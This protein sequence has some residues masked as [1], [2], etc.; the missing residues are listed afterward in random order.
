VG[1]RVE[2]GPSGLAFPKIQLN[3]IQ[4]CPSYGVEILGNAEADLGG[5]VK[6]SSGGNTLKGNDT[7]GTGIDVF[8]GNT[9][10]VNA[11]HNFWDGTDV[12]TVEANDV[13]DSTLV[14]VDPLGL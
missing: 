2:S 4:G 10:P 6:S 3:D 5:G 13:N 12:P 9:T 14:L 8:N 11:Q 1:I 7:G